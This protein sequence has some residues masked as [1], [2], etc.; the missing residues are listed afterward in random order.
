MKM[1]ERNPRL[2][3]YEEQ[4]H[5]YQKIQEEVEL[6]N[7][8]F[9]YGNI[10]IST[11]AFKATLQDEI[12][13]WINVLT[14]AVHLKYKK[15]MD[16]ILS[17]LADFDKKLDRQIEDLDDIRIIMET[18]K[19][20]REIEIDLDMRIETVEQA[21]VLIAKFQ[22]QLSK[23]EVERVE[24]LEGTWTELQQKAMKV[25]IMLLQVQE[26]FQRELVK[27]LVLFEE[28]CKKFVEEY[29]KNGPMEEGLSPKQASDRL[30][31]FQNMFETLWKKHSGYSV[32]EELFGLEHTEQVRFVFF[33]PH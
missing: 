23:E 20:I 18:Q 21:F 4:L 31:M 25:Q 19:K 10:L 26:H 13:H 8:E 27:N 24:N 11:V 33:W 17:I 16:N 14:K 3:E 7:N 32:G 6:E 9:R 12:K 22:F 2:K 15:D 5:M 29:N 28:E 30:Q 1:S